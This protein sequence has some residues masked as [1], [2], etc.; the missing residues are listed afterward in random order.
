[1]VRCAAVLGVPRH[2]SAPDRTRRDEDRAAHYRRGRYLGVTSA[3]S[4][5]PARALR[6]RSSGVACAAGESHL[7]ICG[8]AIGV[9]KYLYARSGRRTYRV[10]GGAEVARALGQRH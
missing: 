9:A 6:T 3:G 10:R 4:P 7:Q 5:R 1:M 2:L 8:L